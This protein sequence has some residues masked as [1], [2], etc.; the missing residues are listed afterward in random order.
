M[1][2]ELKAI[3]KIKETTQEVWNRNTVINDMKN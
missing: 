3:G 2:K 1:N